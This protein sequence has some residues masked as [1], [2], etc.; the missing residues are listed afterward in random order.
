[1]F[2]K[3]RREALQACEGV[4]DRDGLPIGEEMKKRGGEDGWAV[5]VREGRK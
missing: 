3:I 1:V 5:V 2:S 4:Q